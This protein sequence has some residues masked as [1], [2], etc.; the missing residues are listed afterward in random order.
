MTFA[1]LREWMAG[2]RTAYLVHDGRV[3]DVSAAAYVAVP[4]SGLP[5]GARIT[6]D[7]AKAERIA[8]R[9]RRQIAG[10]S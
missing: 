10:R 5:V 4:L 6:D 2:R 1:G 3:L 8:E 9:Q 7:S